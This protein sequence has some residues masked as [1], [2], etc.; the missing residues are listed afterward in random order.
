MANLMT[1]RFRWT[2]DFV[3]ALLLLA[4]G[5]AMAQ[6][7]P[8]DTTVVSPADSAVILAPRPERIALVAAPIHPTVAPSPDARMF[9]AIQTR[10]DPILWIVPADG[11]EPYAFR[12]M[13]AAYYPRWSPSGDRVGFIAAIGPPRVWTVE[14]DPTTGRPMDPPRLLIY[15]EA[16]AFAFSPDGARLALVGARS[17]AA[18][19]SEIHIIDWETRKSLVLL[20]ERGAIY[21]LDWA[22]DARSIYYGLV[23]EAPSLDAP[24]QIKAVAVASGRASRVHTGG[25]FLG[26]A[27]NGELLLQRVAAEDAGPENLVEVVALNDGS[28]TRIRLPCGVRSVVWAANSDALILVAPVDDGDGIWQIPIRAVSP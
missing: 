5:P 18:G 3:S 16:N 23:P 15:I 21:R 10:P 7:P 26:L 11:S 4:A 27:P 12:K 20:R 28:S 24:H 2:A 19:A 17:T 6:A 22:P 25:E 13:W 8:A 1:T 9:A 14:I